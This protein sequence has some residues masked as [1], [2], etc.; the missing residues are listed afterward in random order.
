[1]SDFIEISKLASPIYSNGRK[2]S[3]AHAV[4]IAL[5]IIRTKAGSHGDDIHL[6]QE[7]ENLTKYADLI[8]AAMESER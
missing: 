5:E 4:T 2:A 7:F 8:Q 6:E 1:M 3:R